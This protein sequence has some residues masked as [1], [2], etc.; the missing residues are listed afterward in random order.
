[1]SVMTGDSLQN[2][3]E[4]GPLNNCD[5]AIAFLREG[6]D[7]FVIINGRIGTNEER[8]VEEYRD[9]GTFVG[10]TLTITL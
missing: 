7:H 4:V 1:M 2:L 6:Q 5:A 9:G 8:Q 10:A 3:A